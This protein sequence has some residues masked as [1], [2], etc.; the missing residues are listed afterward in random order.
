[1]ALFKPQ[2][3]FRT[4]AGITPQF[5]QQ[6]GITALVLDVDNTLTAHGSQQLSEPIQNWLTQMQDAGIR[7]YIVSNNTK[8]RVQPFAQRLGLPFT[9]LSCKPAPFGFMRVRKALGV[10]KKQMALVGDQLF[11]DSMGAN[12]YG[13]T[14]LLCV[15]L[16]TDTKP[17]IRFK[18]WL[19]KPLLR[20]YGRKGLQI[21]E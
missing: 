21:R 2:F 15:P 11:T 14:M 12:L 18:R 6:Q 5:L 9:S 17:S 16:Y 8:K 10:P 4:A 1:M 3:R 20:R 19:E 7:M 13:I